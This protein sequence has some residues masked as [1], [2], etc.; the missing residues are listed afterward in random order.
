MK[1]IFNP[2]KIILMG[3]IVLLSFTVTYSQCKGFAKKQIP[4]LA[5]FI[6]N[7]QINSSI[8]LSGDNA[9]LT[10]TFYAGQTYRILVSA[11][12]TLG[13]VYFIMRD[14]RKKQLFNSKEQGGD[15]DYWDFT[16]ESTQQ[17]TIEVVVP[18]SESPTGIVPS[19]CVSIL[20]GFKQ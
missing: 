20:V 9:E 5:P 1:K 6:H 2:V 19:G 17:L 4:K 12:E 3:A 7:G 18:E 16:V 11:Q 10:L 14:A 8:L 15:V 13:K